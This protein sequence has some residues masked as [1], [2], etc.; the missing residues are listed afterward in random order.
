MALRQAHLC[1]DREPAPGRPA[2]SVTPSGACAGSEQ[3][4]ILVFAVAVAAL[5]VPLLGG[6]LTRLATARVKGGWAIAL[7][8]ALQVVIISIIPKQMVGWPGQA[9][10]L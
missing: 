3:P 6:S 5:S 1:R 8:L 4:V 2:T 9:V 10:E 7:A